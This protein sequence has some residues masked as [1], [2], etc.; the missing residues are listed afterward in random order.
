MTVPNFGPRRAFHPRVVGLADLPQKR[1]EIAA[2]PGG[3]TPF[4][5]GFPGRF[6]RGRAACF[7]RLT[8]LTHSTL[9]LVA[10][11]GATLVLG[12][13][14]PV[15][16]PA[17]SSKSQTFRLPWPD[18]AGAY[19]LQDITLSTFHSP[20]RL[21]GDAAQIIVDPRVS[22][23]GVVGEVPI[24]R[25]VRESGKMIPADFVTLQGAVI[26][27]HTEKLIDIDKSLG[28]ASSL[29]GRSR[30]GL[31]ARLS[32][33]PYSPLIYNN[34]I[35]DGRIDTLFFVPFDGKELPI[36]F[37]AGIIAHE[38]FHRLFNAIVVQS[39]QRELSTRVAPEEV[40]AQLG[41]ESAAQHDHHRCTSAK[42]LSAGDISDD[43]IGSLMKQTVADD[44]PEEDTMIPR[45]V[46][47]QTL[48]RGLNEGLA[49]YWGWAYA[50]DEEFV[51]R[52]LG[53]AENENRRLDR[54]VFGFPTRLAFRNSLI[55]ITRSGAPTL[56]SETGRVSSAYRLGTEYARV[57]RGLA[58]VSSAV[59]VRASVS[60]AFPQ[61]ASMLAQ[62]WER[63][64]LEPEE[65][66]L[67][68]VDEIFRATAAGP[69][70]V[71]SALSPEQVLAV[72]AELR[73]LEAQK[74][75]LEKHCSEAR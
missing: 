41:F 13:C 37:N 3:E 35:F 19:R 49:D 44:T 39:V 69:G 4:Y 75:V 46:W 60:R 16:D 51:G 50:R 11:I 29:N 28:V 7:A 67:P 45:K 5:S 73:R 64:N 25:W 71:A 42:P 2:L 17:I 48:L 43:L 23:R 54:Q 38:H 24:G 20:E 27:A 55:T 62:N 47:N 9:M 63:R 74:P 52:S 12:A 72:C 53:K 59:H 66:L 36:A 65:L 18:G 57:L 40:L 31:L 33:T 32:E 34:A 68:V 10:L 8:R 58:D 6:G 61:I 30:I 1:N 21:E 14:S 56:K 70:I 22:G 15:D 26:Y